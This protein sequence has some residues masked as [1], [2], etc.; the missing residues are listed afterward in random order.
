MGRKGQ[1][2]ELSVCK[3]LRPWWQ[4]LE[5]NVVFERTP[6][7]GGWRGT[8]ANELRARGDVMV[9]PWSRFPFSVEVKRVE[10][11]SP[12]VF[13]D[14]GGKPSPV[15]SWWDQAV[16][17]ALDCGREPMLWFRQN[18]RPWRVL[19]PTSVCPISPRWEWMNPP[20]AQGEWPVGIWGADLLALHPRV[21]GELMRSQ[22]L[23]DAT[24]A[25][26]TRG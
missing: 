7:S 18:R 9:S 10:R 16:A 17:A 23:I 26:E 2:G 21:F 3:L 15:W 22:S 12:N 11:W 6:R 24:I 5:P 1:R 13:E 25:M 8:L 14:P 20:V 4:R 19:L